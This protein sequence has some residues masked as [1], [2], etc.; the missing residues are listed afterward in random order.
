MIRENGPSTVG[1]I[2][3]AEL[4]ILPVA[5][6]AALI[7]REFS[8]VRLFPDSIEYLSFAQNILEGLHHNGDITLARYRRPPL[9]SH[10]VALFSMGEAMPAF[11]ADVGR[12]VS[13]FA[14]ALLVLPLYFLGRQTMGKTA[15]V[16]A[17]LLAAIT[18]ELLY[19]SG[20]VLTESLATL[21]VSV[22]MYILWLGCCRRSSKVLP[23]LLGCSLG[24]GFLSRHLVIGYLCIA[25]AWL[26]YSSL[27]ARRSD[28]SGI[29]PFKRIGAECLILLAGF[30]LTV[31]PQILYL[32]SETGRWALAVDPFSISR[33]HVARAGED[34]RYTNAYERIVSLTSDAERYLWEVEESPGL[35]STIVNHPRQYAKAYVAT[36]FRGYLPDTYP[37]PYPTIIL[38]LALLGVVGLVKERKFNE[39]LF[40]LWG[41]GGYYLFLALFLNMRDRYMFTSYPLVLLVAGAGASTAVKWFCCFVK[42]ENQKKRVQLLAKGF[43]LC[44]VAAILVPSSAALIKE[45]KKRASSQ[46]FQSA[47]RI[48][49]KRIEKNAV[50]FD[51]TPHLAYF[52]GGIKTSPP[53]AEIKDI[54]HFARKRGVSY[55]VVSSIYVPRLRPQYAPLLNPSRHH[56]GLKPVA[57]YD[58]KEFMIIVY[59][60]L[61]AS[62]AYDMSGQ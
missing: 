41:F 40:C 56:D 8:Q 22:S 17:V 18:P 62:E 26:T 35:L 51:R 7:L 42:E 4:F 24:L 13:V 45:Q 9:Y 28:K 50:M 49:S 53:Y 61:P 20:A 6:L 43:M 31:S 54:L 55:W 23:F 3:R 48:L 34:I 25:L 27:I 33:E 16:A 1:S 38:V 36:L 21:L 29:R 15:S 32:H 5:F 11:L 14:G 30:F 47:G 12:Q 57:V 59:R 44:L 2:T 39:L 37:L 46:F 52:S 19:Y 60:I 10:L 58:G